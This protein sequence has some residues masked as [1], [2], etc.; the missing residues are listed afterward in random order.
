[1]EKSPIVRSTQVPKR[2]TEWDGNPEG[3]QSPSGHIYTPL[4]YT[5]LHVFDM[6]SHYD[7]TNNA[8]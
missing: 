4:V 6:I 2:W 7:N 1:M 8:M 5:I 3:L